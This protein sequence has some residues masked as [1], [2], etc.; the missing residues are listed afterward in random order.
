MTTPTSNPPTAT[1]PAETSPYNKTQVCKGC[2]GVYPLYSER[3]HHCGKDSKYGT[4]SLGVLITVGGMLLLTPIAFF[5]L[6][7]FFTR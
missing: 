3:C 5:L 2:G 6:V 7:Y 4:Q 1:P